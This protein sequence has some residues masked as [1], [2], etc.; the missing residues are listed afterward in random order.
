MRVLMV[1]QFFLPVTGGEERMVA[2]LCAELVDRGVDV[3]VA[4]STVVPTDTAP[5]GVRVYHVPTT[6]GRIGRLHHDATRRHLPPLPDPGAVRALRAILAAESPHVVHAH[7]WLVHSLVP[8]LSRRPRLPV[9]MS[10]HDYGL[11]CATRRLLRGGAP[12]PG[13]S[14]HACMRCAADHYGPVK[15]A[16]TA[17]ALRARREATETRVT[18]FLPVSSAVAEGLDLRR[19]GL[20]FQTIANFIPDRLVDADLPVPPGT[21]R[22]PYM[23]YAG[24]LTYDKGVRTLLDAYPRVPGAPPLVLVGRRLADIPSVLPPGVVVLG[25]RPHDQVLGLLRGAELALV[26]SVWAEP[27]GLVC[28]E[29]LAMGTPVIGTGLGGMRDLLIPGET[30]LMVPPR[31]PGALAAA[32]RMLLDDADLRERLGA[33]GIA[34]ARRFTA[35]QVVPRIIDVYREVSGVAAPQPDDAHALRGG[36]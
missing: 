21:P 9:L 17:G 20:P 26:P 23:A 10:L 14:A 22:G 15:G 12:C 13:P 29:A 16:V 34:H 25:E 7:N 6:V 11:R 32:M 2:H 19:A 35:S 3:A 31:D 24:D 8:A 30:G 18:R 5:P 4:T 1:T 27:F 36:R 28:L 33:A